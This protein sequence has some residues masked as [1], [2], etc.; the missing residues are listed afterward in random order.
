MLF[1]ENLDGNNHVKELF[2]IK[3]NGS[4]VP[5]NKLKIIKAISLSLIHI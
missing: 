1:D 4:R 2:V 3:R 5:F